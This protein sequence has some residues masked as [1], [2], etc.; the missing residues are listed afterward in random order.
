MIAS[1]KAK[2][3]R[4]M[5]GDLVAIIQDEIL[6]KK[7][8]PGERVKEE[9]VCEEL[10]ISRTPV[11]EALAVLAQQGLVVQRPHR[12]TVVATFTPQEIIDLLR[13]ES[14]VEGIA[15]AMA[16]TNRT[17]EQLAEL[18]AL[19]ES[20]RSSLS[21]HFDPEKFYNYD[22]KF[23]AKLVECT[24]SPIVMRIV[25]TQLALI[26]LCRYF[27]ITAPNRFGHSVREHQQ[28][29][30]C[31][32]RS[33]PVCA[34]SAARQHMESVINDYQASATGARSKEDVGGEG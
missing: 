13:L 5:R 20:V 6:G 10:G 25:E 27:T 32:R 7:F 34:E 19:T 30:E 23:H 9:A 24:G 21:E 4:T 26:Y 18:E 8:R 29:I 3:S 16:A 14:A 31:L 33:D 28:I 22:R 2:L 12:G 17:P 11:R 1:R 15:A